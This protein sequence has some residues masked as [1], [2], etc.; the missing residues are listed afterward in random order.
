PRSPACTPGAG[1]YASVVLPAPPTTSPPAG[2]LARL[3]ARVLGAPRVSRRRKAI[4]LT[5]AVLADL[6]QLVLWP[7]FAGGAASP[8]AEALAVAVALALL[9][10][11]GVSGRLALALVLELVPGADLFPTWTAVVATIPVRD[12]ASEIAPENAVE[13]PGIEPGSARPPA[14]LRSRA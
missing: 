4:A 10:T 1:P 11:L 9:M 7:A 13:A 6:T 14:H 5:I 3:R 2:A 8:F 12:D